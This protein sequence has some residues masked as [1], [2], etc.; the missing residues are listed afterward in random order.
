VRI[1]SWNH[2]YARV[3]IHELGVSCFAKNNLSLS[4]KENLSKSNLFIY[5]NLR[6]YLSINTI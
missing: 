6:S 5:L 3:V 1:H 4:I 2:T